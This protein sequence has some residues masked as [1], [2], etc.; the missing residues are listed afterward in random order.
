MYL[1]AGRC[2]GHHH[3]RRL[4]TPEYVG[5]PVCGFG[6]TE[7]AARLAVES[8]PVPAE[9]NGCVR[10]AGLADPQLVLVPDAAACMTR[11]DSRP[12]SIASRP[13]AG[14]HRRICGS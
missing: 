10:S 5:L 9:L 13:V 1:A 4:V 8:R 7:G 6:L 14:R 3:S 2:I 12:A 11:A